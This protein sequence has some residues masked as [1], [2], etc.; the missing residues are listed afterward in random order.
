MAV[1]LAVGVGTGHTAAAVAA[2]TGALNIALLD[3]ALPRAVMARAL[4]LCV[5]TTTVVGF[6]AVVVGTSWWLVP[7]LAVL[8]FLQ[9]ALAGGGVSVANATIANM[10]TAIIFSM[11]AGGPGQAGSLALWL[12]VG[13]TV[14]TVVALVA[15]PWERQGLLRRQVA[16]A[17]RARR[18]GPSESVARW[19]AAARVTMTTTELSDG[20]R[21]AFQRVLR[22]IG[23]DAEADPVDLAVAARRVRRLPATAAGGDL[24]HRVAEIAAAP[25]PRTHSPGGPVGERLAH[26]RTLLMPGSDTFEAGLRQALLMVAGTVVVLVVAVPQGHWVLLVFALA[27]RPDYSG[28]VA[29]LVARAVGVVAGVLL[30]SALVA[31]SGGSVALLLAGAAVAGILL[32]R[33]VMGNALM[34]FLWL[35]IFVSLMVD[36]ADPSGGDR[37]QRVVATL[38]GVGIGFVVSV[39]WPGWRRG[40][41]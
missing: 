28:T 19:V 8:A 6:V 1:I 15:W 40:V 12:A 29:A 16:G 13:A 2:T 27:I 33:W 38:I 35:T 32:C 18:R 14:E 4:W 11:A 34:F 41:G 5:V 36:V 25:P 21:Q 39:A 22:E 37:M 20:E 10:I 30:V 23:S 9:G 24:S 17:L 7:F 31:V 3:A 26:L